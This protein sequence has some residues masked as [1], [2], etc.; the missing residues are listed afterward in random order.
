MTMIKKLI[1]SVTLMFVL[2]GCKSTLMEPATEQQRTN[3]APGQ[4]QIVFMRS[5][6]VGHAIQASVFDVTSGTPEF[7]GII[8]NDTQL[9]HDTTPGEHTFMVVGESADFLKADLLA[10]KAYYSIVTPR[11][12]FW[13]ARFSLHPVRGEGNQGKF[14]Y[15]SKEFNKMVKDASFV[16][17]SE[18]AQNWANKNAADISKKLAKYL[19]AWNAKDVAK[20]AEATILKTDHL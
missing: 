15:D 17:T 19:P 4:S 3:V 13:K 12:G 1:A 2:T 11:M 6:F 7:I 5:S 8:S 9:A 18:K 14:K 16:V 20:Q 10:D